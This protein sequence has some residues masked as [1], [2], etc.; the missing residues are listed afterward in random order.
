MDRPTLG[1]VL[2]DIGAGEMLLLLVLPM[3][4]LAAVYW[5]VRTAVRDGMRDAA[6][7]RAPG[8]GPSDPRAG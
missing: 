1:I 8:H 7:D 4:L 2:L 3:L 6:R 5:I